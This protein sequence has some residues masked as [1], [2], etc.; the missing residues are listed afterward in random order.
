MGATHYQGDWVL[1]ALLDDRA[2]R[3]GDER[4]VLSADGDLS[5]GQVRDRA[6]RVAAGLRAL[7]VRPGDRVATMLDSTIDYLAAWHGI[8]WA[9]AVDVPVN[10]ELRGTFLA[11]VLR[12]S[13]CTVLFLQGRW[14][15]RLAGLALPDLEHVVVVGEPED[16]APGVMLHP[17]A[18]LLG[19]A[20]APAAARDGADLAHIMYTS[21]TTG[22]SK[23]VMGSHRSACWITQG[24]IEA[25]TLGPEDVG[26]SMFPLFHTMGR[27]AMVTTSFWV[28][29]PVVL[30][31]RFSVS[32]FWDDVRATGA[33]FFGYFGAVILFLWR[34]PERPGDREHRVRAAFG[35]SAPAEIA[36]AWER[37]FG[38]KLV[39]VYG[40]TELGLAAIAAPD[41]IRRGTMGRPVGHLELQVHD[42]RGERLPP[43]MVGEIVGR[44]RRPG[45]IFSGYWR[46]PE[47]T[48]RAFR[49]LWFH[50]GD[51]GLIDA[52]GY[53]VFRDRMGDSIR[54]R[55]QQISSFEVEEAVR[56]HPR[57][58]EC[59]AFA[60][61]SEHADDEVMVAVVLDGDADFAAAD[62]C[63]ELVALMPRFALPRYI[64]VV[65]SLPKTP[66]QRVQKYRL[67]ADGV[68]ADTLD[69]EALGIVPARD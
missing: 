69:R 14:L 32:G 8:V 52:D 34:E 10:G 1:G 16:D 13:G 6:Q 3:W 42:E 62:L 66:T 15:D 21:G 28:R 68:T 49:D 51:A 61:P 43:G 39:E 36:D 27:G 19:H 47:E 7:G 4:A 35:A 31:P 54:R 58:V 9:G 50:S 24:Y 48:L 18:G 25:L 65:A 44:P 46:R 38:V 2:E 67:R 45:A 60:V 11:H 26:Y 56:S 30:R 12:D 55:G 40:S 29:C 64:R 22:A 57:V 20:P 33:T 37:R 59:A 5:Y 17:F 23:G 63:A 41:A 53:V